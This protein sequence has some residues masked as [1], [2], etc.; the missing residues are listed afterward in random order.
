MV[1]SDQGEINPW[2]KSVTPY[3]F[4][5]KRTIEA[6]LLSKHHLKYEPIAEFNDNFS[7]GITF[8]GNLAIVF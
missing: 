3:C 8:T 2:S 4:G 7:S 5:I 1:Y 6:E